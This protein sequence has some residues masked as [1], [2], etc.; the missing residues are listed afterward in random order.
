MALV[1]KWRIY[2]EANILA[3]WLLLET[4]SKWQRAKLAE[5]VV[6]SHKL[7]SFLLESQG[8]EIQAFTSYWAIYEALG[9]I[10]RA[11]VNTWMV[12]DGIP[13]NLYSQVKDSERYEI[14]E[15]QVRKIER[16]VRRLAE[17]DK[18]HHRLRVLAEAADLDAGMAL[19]LAKN[20]EAPDSFHVGIALSYGCDIFV[21]RDGDF[22]RVK[23]FLADKKVEVMTSEEL[24]KKLQS[25]GVYKAPRI[26]V[27]LR[28][29]TETK[30]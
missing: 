6:A 5:G 18:K 13:V 25:E 20:L 12:L 21:T 27:E 2:I 10:K 19:I 23:E 24:V 8:E 1:K 22:N 17:G 4:M 3:D 16:L 7:V 11:S 15:E 29:S 26:Q 9:V 30:A 28:P 14:Q